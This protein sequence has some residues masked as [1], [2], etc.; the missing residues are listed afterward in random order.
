MKKTKFDENFKK[1]VGMS[2]NNC[3][4]IIISIVVLGLV[5]V[6]ITNYTDK[7]LYGGSSSKSLTKTAASP[8]KTSDAKVAKPATVPT[9]SYIFDI[10]GLLGKN[11]DEIRKILGQPLDKDMTEPTAEQSMGGSGEWDNTFKKDGQELLVTFNFKTRTVI[12]YFLSGDNKTKLLQVGNLKENDPRYTIE[13][14]K[15]LNKPTAI[16][17]IKIVPK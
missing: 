4:A 9:P 7:T 12:D 11:I 15:Q 1:T 2:L 5:Y 16:T 10:P 6:A 13:P 3:I 8:P 17:G 14:V